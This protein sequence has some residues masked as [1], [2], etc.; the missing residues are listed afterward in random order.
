MDWYQ[1]GKGV[2]QGCILSPCLFNLYAEYIMRNAELD[3][4]QAGIKIAG[5]NINNLRNADNITLMAESEELKS[6]LTKVKEESENVGLKVNIQKTKI[7]VSSPITSWQ[8]DGETMETVTDFIFL[9]SQITAD[10]DCSHEIKRHLLLG[11]KAMTNLDSILKSRDIT[12]PINVCLV[13]AMVFPAVRYGCESWTIKKAER[14][15]DAFELWCWRRLLRVP[16]TARRSKQSILKEV[17]PEYSLEGQ[18]MK[19]ELQYFGHLIQR[20]DLLEKTLMLG[21]IEGRRRR[22]QQRMRWLDGI[23]DSTDMSLSKLREVVMDRKV[24]C[25]AVHEIT[26]SWTRLSNWKLNVNTERNW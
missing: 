14:A 20:T 9:G 15:I 25:A 2:R 11:R 12:L 3:E 19:L 22:G 6:L 5:K 17:S 24:W 23:T 10:G 4:A 18:M 8:I 13:K 16:W 21:M 1:T 26:K 7:M